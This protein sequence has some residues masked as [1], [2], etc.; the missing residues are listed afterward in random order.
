MLPLRDG[1]EE[2]V[3]FA[4][5]PAAHSNA[6]IEKYVIVFMFMVIEKS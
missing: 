1:E 3:E 4:E 6:P 5:H 2:P